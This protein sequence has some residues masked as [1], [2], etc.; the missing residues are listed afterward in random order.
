MTTSERGFVTLTVTLLVMIMAISVAVFTTRN[1]VTE[2]RIQLNEVRHEQ[3]FEAAESGL[4]YAVSQI[5]K[6]P[7]GSLSFT[8]TNAQVAGAQTT[9]TTTSV[10][11]AVA[12]TNSSGQAVIYSVARVS[13]TG[14]SQDGST[15]ET[16][17]QTLVVTPVVKTGPS[18]PLTVGGSMTVG[19]SFSVAANPNGGGRGVPVSIWMSTPVDLSGNVM[20]CGQQEF[21]G[22]NCSSAVYSGKDSP[23]I[24]IVDN[25][26]S[27]PSDLF[28]FTFGIDSS[29]WRDLE[30][31]ANYIFN[32]CSSLTGSEAGLI[33]IEGNCDLKASLGSESA[34]VLLLVVDGDLTMN[35]SY[36]FHGVVFSFHTAPSV[37]TKFKA[38]GTAEVDGSII[39]N[40]DV[41]I[42]SGTFGVRSEELGTGGGNP[43][44]KIKRV[45]RLPGSWRDW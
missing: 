5:H 27:F 45:W 10:E 28:A 35:A 24:D 25:D 31:D 39:A 41:D 9:F 19:G 21:S 40:H 6:N 17:R 42:T 29:N 32:D 18:A 16:H 22:G 12:F 44:Q 11:D 13:S 4:E 38:N 23:G 26:P 14:T 43:F 30:S 36:S 20:T 15:T 34:P 7:Q 8:L 33:I 1:K 37:S 2:N 3:A